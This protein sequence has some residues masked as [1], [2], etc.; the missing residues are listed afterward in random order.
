MGKASSRNLCSM[1]IRV[2][3]LERNGMRKP[4]WDQVW[5]YIIEFVQKNIHIIIS[6]NTPSKCHTLL[7]RR[8]PWVKGALPT[9]SLPSLSL[10]AFI[11]EEKILSIWQIRRRLL[12]KN[13]MEQGCL[14]GS[15]GWA[16]SSWSRLRSWSHGC[17]FEPCI[18]LQTGHGAY[19]R[20]NK[21]KDN[22]HTYIFIYMY[23]CVMEHC[24]QILHRKAYIM[25]C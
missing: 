22:I 19:L 18:G 4:Q 5:F 1:S 13:M 16:S 11:L 6:R 9:L 25:S 3:T 23:V 12:T 2:F 24:Y 7:Y 17:E 8:G 21:N 14:G 10:E 20:K 15:V